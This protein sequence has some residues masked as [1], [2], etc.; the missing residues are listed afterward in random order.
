MRGTRDFQHTMLATFQTSCLL[1]GCLLSSMSHG[2]TNKEL[3]V[4]TAPALSLRSVNAQDLGYYPKPSPHQQ[5]TV[6][7][8]SVD[9]GHS[10][11]GTA[12]GGSSPADPAA[13]EEIFVDRTG[14]AAVWC[15]LGG[16]ITHTSFGSVVLGPGSHGLAGGNGHGAIS[17]AVRCRFPTLLMGW[18]SRHDGSNATRDTTRVEGETC[19][20]KEQEEKEQKKG[21]QGRRR[22]RRQSQRGPWSVCILRSP[23][24]VTVHYPN[25][26]SY[27][28]ALPCE[29]RLLQPLGEGLLVQRFSGEASDDSSNDY[30]TVTGPRGESRDPLRDDFPSIGGPGSDVE[31]SDTDT[32]S[33]FTLLHPL[34]ELRPVALLPPLVA[35]LNVD[36]EDKERPNSQSRLLGVED[37]HQRFVCDAGERVVFAGGGGAHGMGPDSSLLLTYHAGRRRHSLWLVLPVPEPPEEQSGPKSEMEEELMGEAHTA[38][39]GADVSIL[40][41]LVHKSSGNDTWRASSAMSAP[42]ESSGLS[43]TLLG[44]SALDSSSSVTAFSMID[45]VLGGGAGASRLPR[46]R[47]SVGNISRVGGSMGRGRVSGGAGRRTSTGSNISWIAP[48]NTRN[49]ALANALGLGQS[50]LGI[51]PAPILARG[52]GFGGGGLRGVGDETSHVSYTSRLLGGADVGGAEIGTI[53]DI[54]T[55]VEDEEED[56]EAQPIRPHHGLSLLWREPENCSSA[57]KHAFC[58]AVGNPGEGQKSTS[59]HAAGS[60]SQREFLVCLVGAQT[61]TLR[62]LSICVN[63]TNATAAFADGDLNTIDNGSIIVKEAFTIPCRAAVGLC[64]TAGEEGEG[65]PGGAIAPN[66]L[67]L[68]PDRRL[69]LHRGENPVTV[70]TIPPSVS[71]VATAGGLHKNDEIDCLSDAV[72]SC[73][74]LETRQGKRRRVRL[75]LDPASPLVAACLGAWD[76]L[77]TPDLAASLRAD[78]V[79]VAQTLSNDRNACKDGDSYEKRADGTGSPKIEG[80]RR[81]KGDSSTGG[82]LDWTALVSVLRELVLGREHTEGEDTDSMFRESQCKGPIGNGHNRSSEG[83][84]GIDDGC[85]AWEAFLSAPHHEQYAR[86]NVMLLSGLRVPN[87]HY[88]SGN[89]KSATPIVTKSS[90]SQSPAMSSPPPALQTR[91][92]EFRAEIGAVLDA[93]HLVLEDMK[94]SRLTTPLVPRLASLLL[95]LARACG[96]NGKDMRDFADHYWRDA[97]GCGDGHGELASMISVSGEEGEGGGWLPARPTRFR[98]VRGWPFCH[99]IKKCFF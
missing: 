52:D 1:A 38:A 71:S 15:T 5:P 29:A 33:L 97:A 99:R 70:V 36:S 89:T 63:D 87:R 65:F 46:D 75:S 78:V 61:E 86:D 2:T 53:G 25:G 85:S 91:R 4:E 30:G 24:L 77:L 92:E 3:M 66:I 26:D 35:G 54:N 64:A 18:S 84:Q 44:V 94:T 13:Q 32:P 19:Q 57:V 14:T 37:Q 22:R 42:V 43:S 28:V 72:G 17:Q 68:T 76:C 80:K 59:T 41:P 31:L 11:G 7:L 82:D 90:E 55:I 48:G 88:N 49:E 9:G 95:S 12:G 69:I 73:F 98:T 21:C 10:R 34:D 45:S 6:V 60:G 58:A 81:W 93:L 27:D 79:G 74:T 40:G 50:A 96:R 8:S 51:A 39:A 23:D 16:Q 67:V 62:A 47:L 56:D 83:S 20:T